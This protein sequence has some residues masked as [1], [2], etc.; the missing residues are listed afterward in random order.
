MCSSDLYGFD[1][2]I[3]D[4]AIINWDFVK[5]DDVKSVVDLVKPQFMGKILFDEPRRGGSGKSARAASIFATHSHGGASGRFDS[6]KDTALEF[7]F[8]MAAIAQAE[9]GA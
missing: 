7:A 4:T 9:K 5:R 2:G 3:Q 6:L 8:A 1:A